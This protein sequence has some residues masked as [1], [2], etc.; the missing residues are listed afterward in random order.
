MK[1]IVKTCLLSLAAITVSV[2]AA[3]PTPL[4]IVNLHMSKGMTG[5]QA[6]QQYWPGQPT[7]IPTHNNDQN[8]TLSINTIYGGGP[9]TPGDTVAIVG[10]APLQSADVTVS[11]DN[12]NKIFAGSETNKIGDTCD[13]TQCTTWK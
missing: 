6:C 8:K 10:G 12:G 5:A 11:D 13:S 2:S 4:H 3:K 7:C 1:T 9:I